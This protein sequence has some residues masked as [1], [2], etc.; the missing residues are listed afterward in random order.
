MTDRKDGPLYL[1]NAFAFCATFFVSRILG[2]SLG[3]WDL[4]RHKEEWQHGPYAFSGRVAA[5]L[6]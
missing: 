1:Y 2:Y 5:P 4:W 3:I 6:T